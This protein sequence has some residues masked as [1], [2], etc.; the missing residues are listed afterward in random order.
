M[1]NTM[2]VEDLVEQVEDFLMVTEDARVAS[3]RARD[4]RDHKQW[5]DEERAKI[6]SRFQAA[7]TV[8][9]I[10]P[11]VEG[12]K[13]LLIN[14][15]TDP[16]AFP[17][18]PKHEKAAEAVTDG[19][20][21]IADNV[22][23]DKV[24]LSVAENDFIEGYGACIV[25]AKQKGRDI[26]I[27]CDHIPWD[28]YYYDH[29]SRR[30]DFED[31]RY[32]GIV[33]WMGLEE[34][35]EKFDLSDEEAEKLFDTS[36]NTDD[37][38]GTFSDRPQWV[39]KKE[40]RIRVCWQ[41]YIH[42]GVWH[43]CYFTRSGYLPAYKGQR[44][45]E[46]IESPYVDE[47][48]EPVNPIISVSANIDRENNRVGE[49]HFW[50]D[51]QDE[52]NHRRSKFLWLLSTRQTAGRKG[53][54]KDIPALKRELS[55]ANGHVEYEGEKGDFEILK[56]SDMADAQ[57]TLYQDGK[58]ELDA[59]G[60]N[61]Q[62]SGERQGDLSG[63]A[64]SNL[65]DAATNELASLFSG[66]ND[67]ERRVYR[68]FFMRMKQFWTAEKWV[69]VID[70]TTKLKWVGFNQ[71]VTLQQALEEKLEDESLMLPQKMEIQAQLQQLME[72]NHPALGNIV[73]VRNA[74]PELVMDIIIQTSPDSINIQREQFELLAQIAQTR[75]EVPFTEVLKLSEL[76]GKDKI[77]KNIEDQARAASEE[78]RQKGDVAF[79]TEIGEK[80]SK[81]AL[82]AAK[83][84][85]ETAAIRGEIADAEKA[86]AE[87]QQTNVQTILIA[88]TPPKDTGIVI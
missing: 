54:V 34:F 52:I 12:L 57:F 26:E 35:K 55:K 32:D 70:D 20:R 58:T 21:F 18:T 22:D 76:R 23:F 4:Y 59:V 86:S 14:R 51:M 42:K 36:E 5:T 82:N 81:T 3:E 87:A 56:T 62:L 50:L 2:K 24:K 6:E 27:Q 8:N 17:R 44:T 65:Q 7:I 85:K 80:Q 9:R 46:P 25:Y 77:I 60:F 10:K 13:G 37:S 68:H 66:L 43:M 61:A 73:E 1:E 48:G 49:V 40:N 69:R 19:L 29:H 11:K 67:F 64:I 78:Q 33:L 84:Q 79:Q 41:F 39:E 74:L 63:K 75:P 45:Y 83:A 71:P 38:W 47:F 72:M 31:K 53:A 30:L 88:E 16:K 28:R 15:K